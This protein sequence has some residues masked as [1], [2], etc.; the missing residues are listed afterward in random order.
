MPAIPDVPIEVDGGV[1][2]KTVDEVLDAGAEIL[3]AG[4][5]VFKDDIGANIRMFHEKFQTRV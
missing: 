2:A 3:V 4:S 1:N 5:A